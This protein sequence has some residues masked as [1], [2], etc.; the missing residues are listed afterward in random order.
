MNLPILQTPTAAPDVLKQANDA[1]VQSLL[2][3]QEKDNPVPEGQPAPSTLF[4]K[5]VDTGDSIFKDAAA[6]A[7]HSITNKT[8][9]L[10]ATINNV[11]SSAPMTYNAPILNNEN[12][13]TQYQPIA[14]HLKNPIDLAVTQYPDVKGLLP[15]VV[16][17]ESS[18][19][20]DT[21]NMKNDAGKYGWIVGLTHDTWNDLMKRQGQVNVP[22]LDPSMLN[23]PQGTLQAAAAILSYQSKVYDKNGNIIGTRDP[24]DVYVNKW[25]GGGTVFTDSMKEDMANRIKFYSSQS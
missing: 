9:A 13:T 8:Q 3:Q 22:K 19:A 18:M 4:Q 17:R 7:W 12:V 15:A 24:T 16:S 23:T 25:N 11:L 21:A 6:T 1:A 10:G 14:P 2:Q 5:Y 20:T